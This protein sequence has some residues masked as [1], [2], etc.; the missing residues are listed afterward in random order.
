M[1]LFRIVPLSALGVGPEVSNNMCKLHHPIAFHMHLSVALALLR[2]LW[3]PH[4]T[5]SP[6]KFFG[7]SKTTCL[8]PATE[9]HL[10][11]LATSDL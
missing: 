8:P 6:N 11:S 10:S 5:D 4:A 9:T 7:G 2:G 1:Q 3:Q